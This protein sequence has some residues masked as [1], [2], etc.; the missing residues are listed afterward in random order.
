M[1]E[2]LDILKNKVEE[3]FRKFG[4]KC[5]QVTT[6]KEEKQKRRYIKLDLN[7]KR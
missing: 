7:K 2:G 5:R 1:I 3:S 6:P 4:E